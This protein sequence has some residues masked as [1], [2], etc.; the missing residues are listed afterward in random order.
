[1]Y[2]FTFAELLRISSS[3]SNTFPCS[4]T[5]GRAR[6]PSIA[7]FS[8]S[9]VNPSFRRA[10]VTARSLSPGRRFGLFCT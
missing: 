9:T 5:N 4:F 3:P 7:L 8:S 2:W 1:M 6:H 10:I